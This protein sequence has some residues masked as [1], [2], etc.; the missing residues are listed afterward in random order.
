MNRLKLCLLNAVVFGMV[1][2]STTFVFGDQISVDEMG[3]ISVGGNLAAPGTVQFDSTLNLSVLTY[4][5]PFAGNPGSVLL[6][7]GS[8]GPLSDIIRF[9]GNGTMEFLSLQPHPTSLV[10]AAAAGSTNIKVA[11]V[12][13]RFSGEQIQLDSGANA[14]TQTIET[15]GTA[16]AAGTGLTLTMP[17]TQAHAFGATIIDGFLELADVAV[18]SVPLGAT[19]TLTESANGTIWTPGASGIGGDSRFPDLQYNFGA[20]VVPEPA[21]ISLMVVGLSVLLKTRRRG[22]RR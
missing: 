20:N 4:S 12:T 14:E 3:N 9:P 11:S 7:D 1:T 8:V 17:L 19:V 16:G 22:S 10:A 2:I 5:L 21:T 13:G 6:R 15:V 18:L